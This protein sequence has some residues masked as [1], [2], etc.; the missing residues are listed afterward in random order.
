MRKLFLLFLLLT[1]AIAPCASARMTSVLVGGGVAATGCNYDTCAAGC[2]LFYWDGSTASMAANICSLG[3]TSASVAGEA[4]LTTN[5]SKITLVDGS[6]N[7]NDYYYFAVESA[8]DIFPA[9]AFTLEITVNFSAIASQSRFFSVSFDASNYV[10]VDFITTSGNDLRIYH[11]GNGTAVTKTFDANLDLNTEYSLVITADTATGMDIS[12][13]G[14]S[15]WIGVPASST[16]TTMT[17]A[18]TGSNIF[19][20]GNNTANSLIG[21]IDNVRVKSGF[22]AG[23]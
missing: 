3:D 21:T 23:Y 11:N 16:I 6:T 2:T 10:F 22:K 19:R 8:Y 15:S 13:N 18:G 9:G 7:G 14:G 20:V 1:L 4:D 12:I 17:H 5:A